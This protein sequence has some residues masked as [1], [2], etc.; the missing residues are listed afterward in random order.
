MN[1]AYYVLKLSFAYLKM[2]IYVKPDS[3]NGH[4]KQVKSPELSNFS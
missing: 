2:G 1:E 4:K 3:V